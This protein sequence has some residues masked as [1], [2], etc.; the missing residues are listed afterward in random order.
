MDMNRDISSTVILILLLVVISGLVFYLFFYPGSQPHSPPSMEP[1][2]QNV[3]L[4][5][6]PTIDTRFK[7]KDVYVIDPR[8]KVR[9]E[10]R[11]DATVVAEKKRGDQLTVIG[12]NEG[13]FEVEF[14]DKRG[15]ILRE[16][17]I[18]RLPSSRKSEKPTRTP[19]TEAQEDIQVLDQLRADTDNIAAFINERA[20]Q[21]FGQDMV[22]GFEIGDGGK[23][24]TMYVTKAW[25]I[26][27]PFQKQV[28]INLVA[29]RYGNQTC[30]HGVRTECTPN[31]FPFINFLNPDNKEIARVGPNQPMQIFE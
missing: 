19:D 31:D 12:A 9:M 1:V 24:L 18:D 16:Q 2:D 29:M 20:T 26:L 30:I 15:W 28:M 14:D 10:P 25:Y 4:F 5:L 6:P 22:S 3:N 8:A 13:W 7:G 11:P 21:L 27:P 23:R 17:V